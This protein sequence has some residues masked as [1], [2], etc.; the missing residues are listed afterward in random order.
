MITLFSIPKAFVGAIA[1]SQLN[2][3]ESWTALDGVEVVLVGDEPGTVEAAEAAGVRHLAGVATSELGTPRLDD[4]FSRVEAVA[5]HPVRCF[6]NADIMLL[7]DFVPAV[8]RVQAA[9]TSFLM[10]GETLDLQVEGRVSP[11]DAATRA[12]LRRRALAEGRSRGATAIDYFAFSARLFEPMPPFV[13][14]RARFDN[15]LVWRAR[16]RGIV[17]DATRGVVAVHQR[18]DYAH[19]PGGLG[20]A[21]FG[22]EAGRNLELAGGK[23]RLYTIH[24]ASHRLTAAGDVRR[25]L[26]AV[27]RVRE[28]LR[29][30]SWKLSRR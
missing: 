22:A 13:V 19:L 12:A 10:I 1:T 29:K 4:A 6:V 28:N 9:R 27:G 23:N 2:A 5:R 15:W 16:E 3:L 21:H 20:E 7:D 14:G 30:I 24:D 25:N 8:R 18:H 26:G 11:A 17:V